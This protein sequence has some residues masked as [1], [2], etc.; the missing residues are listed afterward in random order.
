[1]SYRRKLAAASL[2]MLLLPAI[3][4]AQ[5]KP[6]KLPTDSME[7]ARKY[8]KWFYNNQLDSLVAHMD[9]THRAQPQAL[10]QLQRRVALLAER[11][12]EETELM[13]EKFV[14]SQGARQYR[15]VAKFSII[16]EPMMVGWVM[17]EKGEITGMGLGPA[18]AAPPVDP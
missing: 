14:T 17:N 18:R 3:A 15:R 1:M 7:M 13:E 9:S 8:T 5:S 4:F 16:G 10:A 12:G 2:G 11:A 6:G